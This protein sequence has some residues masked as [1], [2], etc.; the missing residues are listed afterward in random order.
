MNHAM[1]SI[2]RHNCI[3][4]IGPSGQQ[5]HMTFQS[6]LKYSLGFVSDEWCAYLFI[7]V[8]V[9][10]VGIHGAC[11]GARSRVCGVRQRGTWCNGGTMLVLF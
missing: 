11:V 8:T 5:V 3:D 2:H 10:R 4:C 7:L 1:V 9:M 6:T